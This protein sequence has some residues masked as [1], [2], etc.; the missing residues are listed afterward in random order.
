M[1][2][3]C[4]TRRRELTASAKDSHEPGSLAE[5]S[6]RARDGREHQRRLR[7]AH[8]KTDRREHSL[9]PMSSARI[10]S[11]SAAEPDQARAALQKL[12][13][14]VVQDTRMTETVQ[15]GACGFAGDALRRKRRD[16]HQP[17]RPG[18]KTQCRAD[19]ARGRP[20][21]QR[22]IYRACWTLPGEK[23]VHDAGGD[24]CCVEPMK[25]RLCGL[26][27]RCDR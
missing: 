18:A 23:R 27:L 26:R 7:C 24:F 8:A 6:R 20:A 13:F 25:F 21:G 14:L 10:C 16:L 9:L 2:S 22:D 15:A 19:P 5:F 4:F 11:A 17:P 3:K 12:S 1:R